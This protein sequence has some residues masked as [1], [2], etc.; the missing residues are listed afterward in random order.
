MFFFAELLAKLGARAEFVR[1]AEYKSRPE[2]FERSTSTE[3]SAAQRELLM[4]DTWN[5]LARL[6]AKGRGATV[7]Q[8]GDGLDAAPHDPEAAQ[9]LRLV[10][11][12]AFA[13]ELEGRLASN[14]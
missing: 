9:T 11:E 6:I 8:V 1:I 13:D 2:Q 14:T 7:R 5:H 10:D 3:P 12:L 4:T